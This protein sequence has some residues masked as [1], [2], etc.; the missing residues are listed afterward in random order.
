LTWAPDAVRLW[1]AGTAAQELLRGGHCVGGIMLAAKPY[2]GP[3]PVNLGAGKEI[4]TRE[5]AD[6]IAE[7]VGFRGRIVWD[8]TMPNGQ[9]RRSIDA[10]RARELFGFEARPP[11]RQGLERTA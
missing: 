2:A 5:L 7:L 1:G 10:S 8:R 6:L 11:L 4:S 3:E 9:P